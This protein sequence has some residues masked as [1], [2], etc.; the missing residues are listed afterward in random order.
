MFQITVEDSFAAAHRLREYEGKCRQL[1]GHNY[2]V[3]VSLEGEQL[4]ET[5]LL[6]D[7]GEVRRLLRE[8]IEPFDHRLLNDV[9]PFD[10]LNPSAENMAKYFYEELS[11]RLPVRIA[12]VRIWETEGAAAAYRA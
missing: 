10:T 6:M 3:R 12:E 9:P 5:G 2:R 8:I 1:H 11:E 4:D 7:F